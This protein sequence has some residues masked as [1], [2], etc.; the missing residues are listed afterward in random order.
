MS[1]AEEAEEERPPPSS[2]GLP[3]W[4]VV[5]VAFVLLSYPWFAPFL[6]DRF[7][8]GWPLVIVYIL[9]VWLILILA[10]GVVER[11]A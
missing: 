1:E 11:R 8:A 10:A 4:L 7:V 5:L 3:R 9:A 6:Q 2:P